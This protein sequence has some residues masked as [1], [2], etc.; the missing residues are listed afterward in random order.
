LLRRVRGPLGTLMRRIARSLALCPSGTGERVSAC[1][2]FEAIRCSRIA[3]HSVPRKELY[4]IF[5][6]GNRADAERTSALG[7]GL[8]G[9]V[10]KLLLRQLW[11]LKQNEAI[12]QCGMTRVTTVHR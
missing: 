2:R 1:I 6:G 12:A 5:H 3:S 11:Y 10:K 9:K 4:A 7:V 8:E